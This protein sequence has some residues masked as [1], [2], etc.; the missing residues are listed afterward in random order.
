MTHKFL[1]IDCSADRIFAGCSCYLDL[2]MS[3]TDQSLDLLDAIIS[4]EILFQG[5]FV[6]VFLVSK[7]N[8]IISFFIVTYILSFTFLVTLR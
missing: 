6:S 2:K 4:T 5:L 8:I 1:F 3:L 7:L